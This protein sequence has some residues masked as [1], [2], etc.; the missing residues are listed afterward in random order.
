VSTYLKDLFACDDRGQPE[1][2][3]SAIAVEEKQ[4]WDYNHG[5]PTSQVQP[6]NA[7]PNVAL[8]AIRPREGTLIADHPYVVLTTDEQ[9][10]R[11][12]EGFLEYLQGPDAQGRFQRAGFRGF[13]GDPGS[14]ITTADYL[15]G[16]LSPTSPSAVPAVINAVQASWKVIRKSAR[17]LLVVD[18]GS[19]MAERAPGTTKSK[20]D[21]AKEAASAALDGFAPDD[22]VGLWSFSSSSGADPPYREIVAPAPISQQKQSLRHDIEALQPQGQRKALYTTLVQ[23]VSSMRARYE[24]TRINAVVLLTDGGNDDASNNDLLGLL[25]TLRTQPDDAFV[26]VFTVGFYG[27][28]ADQ[29]T[30]SDIAVNGRGGSYSDRDKRAMD[31]ILVAV[32]SNF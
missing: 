31:K 27:N 16:Q 13:R 12:A 14:E 9:K 4:V 19:S 3:V 20:L 32:V 30:L 10:K 2:C 25:Q 15:A 5:N 11:A 8:V 6:T 1:R 24:P 29:Q 18:V 23:A 26:R 21:V 28:T 17:V 7:V 22:A